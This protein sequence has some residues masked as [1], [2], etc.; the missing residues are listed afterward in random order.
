MTREQILN[1]IRRTA[2][3]N[4]GKPLGRNRFEQIT[5]I[6]EYDVGAFWPGWNAAVQEA[7]L[8]P[9]KLNAAHD[10]RFLMEKL[11]GLVR[12]LGHVP[13][14]REMRLERTERDPN[15]PN[16]NVYGRFG[17]K[18]DLVGRA[19]RF[20][21]DSRDFLDVVPILESAFMPTPSESEELTRHVAA[22]NHG[23]VYLARGHPGTY[24]IGRTNLVD[25]RLSE[26]GATS[27]VELE[28]IH[29]I[30]TDDPAGVEAYWH[31]RFADQR[32]KGEWFRLSAADV[33]AFKRWK[34]IY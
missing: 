33:K 28:R 29:H 23:F 27:A 20:C 11:A 6:S 18:N 19:L 14:R 4:G 31:R 21:H 5:G 17:S 32:M 9:N 3:E 25:R 26:L 15:F 30:Q 7:G 16:A 8:E 12:K 22:V 24:K 13:T 2:A 34:R 1:E 10:E